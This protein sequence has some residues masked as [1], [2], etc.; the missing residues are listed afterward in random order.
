[1]VFPKAY[2]GDKVLL[3]LLLFSFVLFLL[4]THIHYAQVSSLETLDSGD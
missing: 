3:L 2:S 1:M 4:L